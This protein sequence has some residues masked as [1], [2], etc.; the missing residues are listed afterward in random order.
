MP[1]LPEVETVVQSLKPKILNKIIKSVNVYWTKTLS[2]HT[3]N[4]LNKII[5]NKKIS[6]ISRRGKYIILHIEYSFL[7]IHLRMTG[8]L[9]YQNS[10]ETQSSHLRFKINFSDNS[11]LHFT[12]IRK[13]G[14]IEFHK[15]LDFLNEKL[16]LE[17]FSNKLTA[18]YLLEK[19][20]RRKGPIKSALLN[21]SI[22]AGIGNIYADEILWRIQIHP[23]KPANQLDIQKLN[24]LIPTIQII[25]QNAIN[26]M[27]TTIINFS[28]DKES[29]GKYGSQLQVFNK[30]GGKCNRCSD[31]I[32]KTKCAGRGTFY[33]PTCQKL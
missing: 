30:K 10:T 13:F 19:L 16:G 4:S 22:V 6:S 3:E 23:Q 21:Q 20:H 26:S 1:E 25:L 9:I 8:K 31:S 12:D 24:E 2:T 7:V 11:E 27:G 18:D 14:H 5:P 32:V 17:P 33:C 28:F 29:Y 15:N